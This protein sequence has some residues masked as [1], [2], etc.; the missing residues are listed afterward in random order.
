MKEAERLKAMRPMAGGGVGQCQ[1]RGR[2]EQG[3]GARWEEQVAEREV[4]TPRG[5]LRATAA[6]L[7]G[8][9]FLKAHLARLGVA[10]FLPLH[11]PLCAQSPPALFFR[12]RSTSLNLL[13]T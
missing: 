3:T 1:A 7:E 2:V 13:Q 12:T 6:M 8:P 10:R 4:E 9:I 5:P 11:I